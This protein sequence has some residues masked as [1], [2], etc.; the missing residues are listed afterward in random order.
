VP[1]TIGNYNGTGVYLFDRTATTTS[2]DR[3]TVTVNRDTRGGGF[4]TESETD[5]TGADGGMTVTVTDLNPNGSTHDK[6]VTTTNATGTAS[7]TPNATETDVIV[8]SPDGSK[9]ET[10]TDYAGS[11][12]GAANKI[13]QAVTWTSA[14]SRSKTITTDLNGDGV[15]DVTTTDSIVT[16]ADGSTTITQTDTNPNGS[17]RD[18]GVETISP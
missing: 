10:V 3:K 18:K 5:V 9:T 12:T 15:I 14:D 7:T 16:N 1:Q 6:S 11:G 8:Y 2:A 13:S 17:L 4:W